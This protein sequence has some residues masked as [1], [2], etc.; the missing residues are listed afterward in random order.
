MAHASDD[1]MTLMMDRLPALLTRKSSPSTGLSYICNGNLGTPP[2]KLFICLHGWACAATDFDYLLSSLAESDAV[3]SERD[4]YVAIDLPGHGSSSKSICPKPGVSEFAAITNALRH[5]L[6]PQGEL[7]DTVLIGHS[8]GCRMALEAFVQEKVNVSGIILIDGS[9]V[10]R[11]PEIHAAPV[12]SDRAT[13]I[14]RVS[15][16][17]GMYGPLT[18]KSFVEGMERRLQDIDLEY[19]YE[20]SERYIEWDRE[21]MERTLDVVGGKECDVKLFVIQSTQGRG[22]NRRALKS[23]EEGPWV[24]FVR[25]KV[26]A[27]RYQSVVMEGCGH[28]PHVD[29]VEEVV[30]IVSTFTQD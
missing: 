10:G 1:R 3:S 26:G 20:L 19:E 16:R 27:D 18:P 30:R 23:G 9:W 5:E 22:A 28:W 24:P 25:A 8:M 14:R 7:L 4:L 12:V 15:D 11:N 13:E 2:R 21:E 17:I 29:K 6:S